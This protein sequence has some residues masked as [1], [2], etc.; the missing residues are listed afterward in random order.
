MLR[1][2]R[3]EQEGR[4]QQYQKPA[5]PTPDVPVRLSNTSINEVI[6]GR[7]SMLEL[8]RVGPM[9]RLLL[10]LPPPSSDSAD[11]EADDGGRGRDN[12][13]LAY[14]WTPPRYARYEELERIIAQRGIAEE[15]VLD[16]ELAEKSDNDN[17]GAEGDSND[18]DD[19][20]EGGDN[21]DGHGDGEGGHDQDYQGGGKDGENDKGGGYEAQDIAGEVV[22]RPSDVLQQIQRRVVDLIPAD[23]GVTA[24]EWVRRVGEAWFRADEGYQAKR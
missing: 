22:V 17:E 1:E 6:M 19:D 2:Q 10:P 8:L 20:G 3:Q 11:G 13:E 4:A 15:A 23:L 18:G 21:R 24:E 14:R 16:M 12:S 5:S 9:A 7:I